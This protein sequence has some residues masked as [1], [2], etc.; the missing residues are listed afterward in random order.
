MQQDYKIIP[1]TKDELIPTASRMKKEGR[2]LTMVHGYMNTSNQP[3]ISY[4]FAVDNVIESY[5]ITGETEVPTISGIYDA[6]AGWPEWEINEL[7]GFTFTGLDVSKR[8][9][10]PEDMS[11]GKGQIMVTPLKELRKEAFDDY[12]KSKLVNT[13]ERDSAENENNGKEGES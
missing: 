1:I 12:A 7:M 9:F 6:A 11:N 2:M 10:L 13:L 3:V 8:L 4:E 5:Q